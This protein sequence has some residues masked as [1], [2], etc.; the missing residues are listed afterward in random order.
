MYLF[1]SQFANI[2]IQWQIP[3]EI[4]TEE[5]KVLLKYLE[6]CALQVLKVAY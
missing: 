2:Y 4:K 1:L 5:N 6:C 3:R